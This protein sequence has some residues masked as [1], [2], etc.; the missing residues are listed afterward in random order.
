MVSRIKPKLHSIEAINAA[1][2]ESAS[3]GLENAFTLPASAYTSAE[4]FEYELETIFKQEWLCIAHVSQIPK[5][6]NYL[7][8]DVLGE[9]VMV[10][11]AKD[12]AVR[13]LSRVCPHRAM[14]IMPQGFGYDAQGKVRGFMCPY[15]S[16]TFDLSG[17][18]KGA[19]AMQKTCDFS[20]KDYSLIEFRSEIWEG[21][22]FMTFNSEAVPVATQLADLHTQISPWNMSSMDIVAELE[23]DLD[24]NWKNMIENWMEPYHHMG[25]HVKTLQTMMPATGC[26][27]DEYHPHYTRAHLP[28][29]QSLIDSI[30]EAEARGEHYGTFPPIPNLPEA[31]KYEWTVHV[32]YP[33]YLM[34]TGPN[35]AFWYRMLPISAEKIHL[36]TTILVAKEAQTHPDFEQHLAE[37]TQAL[38][39]FHCEDIEVCTAV[40][41]GFNSIAFQHGR[42]SYLEKPVYQ[43]QCYLA[44]RIRA[45]GNVPAVSLEALA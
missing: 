3:T 37:E 18:L 43:I 16:W 35:C 4:Y 34:L 40:Q 27:T 45:T 39:D 9:P 31:Y 8:L 10:V 38:K 21:F 12:N 29:R 2:L 6:G 42:M 22:V 17:Q 26:W 5:L 20:L 30:K 7:S 14:D 25:I 36:V 23:W 32:G 19:P 1:I 24:V 28:Y 15:H 33:D 41:R 11:R 13:V 44:D